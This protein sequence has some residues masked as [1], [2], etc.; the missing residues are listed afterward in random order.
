MVA[1]ILICV[2]LM[3]AGAMQTKPVGWVILALALLALLFTVLGH[4]WPGK[5]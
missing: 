5:G 2:A 1:L 4:N 3:L